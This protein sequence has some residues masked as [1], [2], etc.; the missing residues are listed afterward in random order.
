MMALFKK[1][2]LV[3]LDIGTS[4]VKMAHMKET[5]R[6]IE[7]LSFDMVTLPPETVVDGRIMNFAAVVER[8]REMVRTNGLKGREATL[9]VSGNFVIIKKLLMTEMTSYELE[10]SLQWEAEQYIPFDIKEVNVDV[11][12]INPRAGHGQMDVLLVAA[13]K[14]YVDEHVSVA[15]EGGLKPMT[16]DTATFA[17]FNMFEANYQLPPGESIALINIGASL[18]NVIVVSNGNMA[19]TRDLGMGGNKLTLEIQKQLN[20]TFEEAE[21]FKTGVEGSL[22]SSTIAREVGRISEHVADD[23]VTEIKRSLDFFM[24]TN[25]KTDISRLYLAGGSAQIPALVRRL[26]NRLGVPVELINP[27]KNI[28]VDSRKFDIDLL[29]RVAPAAGVAIGLGLRKSGDRAVA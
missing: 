1:G 24:A 2:N 10:E 25:M 8:V 28:V 5:S 9:G 26:E 17:V 14:E 18:T 4:S 29:Q 3:G 20:V 12:I 15:M 13:K 23:M 7:L 16:V 19:F 6:G 27:F 11:Q 22:S 21:Q